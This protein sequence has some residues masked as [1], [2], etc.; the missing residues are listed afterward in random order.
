MKKSVLFLA[1]VLFALLACAPNPSSSESTSSEI[2]SSASSEDDPMFAKDKVKVYFFESGVK[3]DRYNP[4]FV[5]EYEVESKIENPG[6]PTSSDPAFNN[7]VGWSFKPIV[8]DDSELW[9][10]QEDT[11]PHY[12]PG[13]EYYLYGQWDYVG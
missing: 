9:D 12:I 8:M 7:F 6:T 13:G 11:L 4:F 3:F 2:P 5:K 1:P 10:F